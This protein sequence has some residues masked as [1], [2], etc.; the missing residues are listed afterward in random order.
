MALMGMQLRILQDIWAGL[1]FHT[2]SPYESL[3][4]Y[5]GIYSSSHRGKERRENRDD[6]SIGIQETKGIGRASS[7]WA[8]LIHRIFEVDPL[9]C[10]KCGGNMRVV[11]FITD[12]Q[13]SKSILKHIR[14][15]TIRSPPLRVKTPTANIPDTVFWDSIPPVESYFHNPGY[16]NWK[17]P[18]VLPDQCSQKQSVHPPSSGKTTETVQDMKI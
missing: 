13:T 1:P 8:R 7:T 12:Y 16:A 5:Y 6:Q 2:P 11:A 4:Y 17:I 15:E 3:V 18:R 10:I 14:E 9:Q